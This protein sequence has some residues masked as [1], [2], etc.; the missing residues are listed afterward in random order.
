VEGGLVDAVLV[1]GVIGTGV[2]RGT[3]DGLWV[4]SCLSGVQVPPKREL[5]ILELERSG[6]NESIPTSSRR[7]GNVSCSDDFPD[8]PAAIESISTLI[9]PQQSSARH[10]FIGGPAGIVYPICIAKVTCHG[11]II[12]SC[13]ILVLWGLRRITML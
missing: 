8:T 6:H 2:S 10:L 4:R 3:P 9:A 1:L 12:V 11:I 5:E 7:R 13:S